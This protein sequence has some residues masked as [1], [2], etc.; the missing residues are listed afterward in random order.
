MRTQKLLKFYILITL[1]IQLI[2]M[3]YVSINMGFSNFSYYLING[4]AY[5]QGRLYFPIL[6]S[7][8]IGITGV[9]AY[10]VIK[11]LPGFNYFEWFLDENSSKEK[12]ASEEIR[13]LR[14]KYDK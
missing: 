9:L 12:K 8:S 2:W 14:N 5:T 13:D 3:L 4:S 10:Q 11:L 7:F 1:A 6:F